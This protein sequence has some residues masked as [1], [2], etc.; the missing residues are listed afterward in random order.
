[1]PIPTASIAHDRRGIVGKHAG[2]WRQIADVPVDDSEQ[3]DDGGLVRGDRIEIPHAEV[4]KDERSHRRNNWTA[5]NPALIVPRDRHRRPSIF[6]NGLRGCFSVETM[7]DLAGI[8]QVL[9]LARAEIDAVEF[10][11]RM[12]VNSQNARLSVAFSANDDVDYGW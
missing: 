1:L 12:R 6:L 9:A 2:H 5:A 10:S 3:R 11:L 4:L 8:D 7:I